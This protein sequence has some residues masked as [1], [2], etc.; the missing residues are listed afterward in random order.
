M[1]KNQ[2]N[3]D[4]L[5]YVENQSPK[6]G[7]FVSLFRAFIMGGTICCF[8]QMISDVL[9]SFYPT[10]NLLTVGA[11][12]NIVVISLTIFLTAFGVFDVLAKYGGAGTFI[13]ISGFANSIAS[14]AIE[15]KKEGLVFGVG[16][17]MFY[18]AGPVL[19]N[20]VAYSMLVGI[21][22]FVVSLF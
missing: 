12:V 8:G 19:V 18:V 3:A 14:C 20:G 11:W 7:W 6:S 10:M 22:Y 1:N 9:K 13:P 2:R 17:K 21:I 4:Y 5:I 15:Y 16:A